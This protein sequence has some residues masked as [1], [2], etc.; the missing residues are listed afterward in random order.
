VPGLGVSPVRGFASALRDMR[1]GH[2]ALELALLVAGILIALAVDG[3]IDDRRDARLERGYLVRL[4]R[5]L[6]Q[7]LK[8]LRE[9]VE[10]EGRQ[11]A[12]G[13]MAYRALRG[14]D[15]TDHEA[16][17][18]AISHLTNRRT[19]RLV[20][21]TYED[22]LSTGNLGLI[23]DASLR[24]TIVKLYEETDRTTT[25]VDRNNQQLVDQ[26]FTLPM[27]D[28]GLLAPRFGANLPALDA[29]LRALG[30]R[31]GLPVDARNDRL[32]TLAMDSPE[33]ELLANRTLRRT[34]VSSS[35]G[36]QAE[37]LRQQVEAARDAVTAAIARAD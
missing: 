13:V 19:L 11:V 17:A 27:A 37:A 29:G 15:A 21:A 1:W 2:V 35:T 18:E 10:F 5:D 12:D 22:L 33:W 30:Q 7:N 31:I 8:I 32:W 20:R 26:L 24:D 9:F 25:L 36:A 16:V 28:S 23:R 4:E 14:A 34:M 6:D 3:W